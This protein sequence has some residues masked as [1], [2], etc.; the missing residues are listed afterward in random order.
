MTYMEAWRIMAPKLMPLDTD[1]ER[2]AYLKL[3]WAVKECEREEQHGKAGK[4][5]QEQQSKVL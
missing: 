2:E 5:D 3:F 1:D 4:A